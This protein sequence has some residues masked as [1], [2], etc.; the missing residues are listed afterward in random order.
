MNYE[1]DWMQYS[2]V[3]RYFQH[4]LMGPPHGTHHVIAVAASGEQDQGG[5]AD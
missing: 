1:G 2:D 3:Y 5:V 4:Y